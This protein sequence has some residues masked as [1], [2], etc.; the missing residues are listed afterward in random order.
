M[1]R[2]V[3]MCGDASYRRTDHVLRRAIH[4]HMP[5]CGQPPS[6]H[7]QQ[8]LPAELAPCHPLN[9]AVLL[10]GNHVLPPA[11][12]WRADLARAEDG[13]CELELLLRHVLKVLVGVELCALQ[14]GNVG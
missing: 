12:R 11:V 3:A 6:E 7:R 4:V 9:S 2:Q 1:M 13:E 8:I 5:R 10:D 14:D